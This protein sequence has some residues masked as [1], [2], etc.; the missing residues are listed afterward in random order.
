VVDE[1]AVSPAELAVS[2]AELVA[3]TVVVDGAVSSVPQPTTSVD[4]TARAQRA[5]LHPF[6]RDRWNV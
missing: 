1:V 3:P 6:R 4:T 5:L 2:P